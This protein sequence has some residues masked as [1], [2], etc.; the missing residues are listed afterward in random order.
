VC[1]LSFNYCEEKYGKINAALEALNNKVIAADVQPLTARSLR[2]PAKWSSR[3]PELI[4][5]PEFR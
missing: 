2:R 3:A 5:G 4:A 1:A